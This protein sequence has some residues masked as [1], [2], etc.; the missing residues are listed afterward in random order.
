MN[1]E[2][3]KEIEKDF[4][5]TAT[6]ENKKPESILEKLLVDYIEN[7][8]DYNAAVIGY[9]EYIKSGRKSTSLEDLKKELDLE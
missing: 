5:K 8:E 7:V 1:I 3:N 6:K 2:I 4:L 9:A